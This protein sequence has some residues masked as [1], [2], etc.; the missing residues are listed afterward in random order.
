MSG[1]ELLAPTQVDSVLPADGGRPG[2]R[3]REYGARKGQVKRRRPQS[4]PS[5]SFRSRVRSSTPFAPQPLTPSGIFGR[6]S[7]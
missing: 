2:R 3:S 7:S 5:A 4:A 6:N 1:A